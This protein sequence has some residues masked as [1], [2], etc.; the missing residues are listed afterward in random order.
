MHI[1]ESS[2]ESYI[3]I[4][5]LIKMIFKKQLTNVVILKTPRKFNTI[6]KFGRQLK[7]IPIYNMHHKVDYRLYFITSDIMKHMLH[8]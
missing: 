1:S 5:E 7:Y 8:I 6:F 2:E 4:F 3:S